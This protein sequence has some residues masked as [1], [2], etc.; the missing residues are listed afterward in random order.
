MHLFVR[1]RSWNRKSRMMRLQ[2]RGLASGEGDGDTAVAALRAHLVPP[3]L[4]RTRRH[5][6]TVVLA[7][8]G[9]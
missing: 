7:P 8:A 4:D 9:S 5:L 6:L 3:S 1:L 2:K